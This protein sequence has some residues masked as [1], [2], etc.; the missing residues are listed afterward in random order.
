ML[1]ARVI[2][3]PA[4]GATLRAVDEGSIAAIPGVRV[5]RV[6]SLVAVVS[7]REWDVV[8]AAS[9]LK[10]EWTGGTPLPEHATMFDAM[11]TS[12]VV[13]Q[14]EVAQ[15]GRSGGA[16]GAGRA[17]ALRHVPV[18]R[19]EPCLDGPV[20]RGCRRAGRPRHDLELHAGPAPVPGRL[21]ADPRAHARAGARHL[22]GRLGDVRAGRCRGRRVRGDAAV[23]GARPAGARAVDA[24]GRARLGSEGAAAAPGAARGGRRGR[25]G[26]GL[27]DPRVAARRHREP[28]QRSVARARCG[29]DRTAARPVHRTDPPEHRSALHVPEHA[30]ARPL[31]RGCAAADLRDPRT[32]EDCQHLRRGVL[33]G[34]DRGAGGRGSARVPPEAP[35]QPARPRGAPRGAAPA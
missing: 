33:H 12:A 26:C 35:D 11:K 6:E 31:D 28:S 10:T 17:D 25:C 27:G 4:V 29:E 24:P 14:Q 9:R 3:P 13:R 5:V 23:E 21:R 1:H 2:H 22:H 19:A 8:R 20:V 15:E 30:R 18:A 16:H 7:E 34:R 32:R